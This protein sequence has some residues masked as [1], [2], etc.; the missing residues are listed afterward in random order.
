LRNQGKVAQSL[1]PMEHANS[2]PSV[3]KHG[4]ATLE[5]A[6][7][8]SARKLIRPVHH[9]QQASSTSFS[10]FMENTMRNFGCKSP[11]SQS[12][13]LKT[14]VL[15]VIASA[16]CILKRTASRVWYDCFDLTWRVSTGRSEREPLIGAADLTGL[17][18][19]G[20]L[21]GFRCQAPT[22]T[23]QSANQALPAAESPP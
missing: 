3:S 17:L 7:V 15:C 21:Q 23:K 2:W 16:D 6:R 12:R 9:K 10:S 5:P 11:N 8:C 19:T 22:K 1:Q 13:V 14:Q 4:A 18:R 20:M